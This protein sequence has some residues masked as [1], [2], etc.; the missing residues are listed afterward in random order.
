VIR[1]TFNPEMLVLARELRGLTQAELADISKTTQGYVSMLEHGQKEASGDILSRFSEVL[2]YPLSFFRQP[3]RYFGF[4]ITFVYHRKK[5]T[6]RVGDLRLLQAQVNLRRIHI[7]RMLRDV[8]VKTFANFTSFDIDDYNGDAEL[9]ANYVR[10][11]WKLPLG[12]IP[13]LVKT[14]E[15][16][17]GVVFKFSFGTTDVD[18]ISQWP[19]DGPP[20][21]FINADT[22]SDRI[23]YSL[24]HELGHVIMHKSATGEIETEADQFAAELLMPSRVILAQL[25]GMNIKLA[26][27]LKPYWR[28][29]MQSLIRRAR[30]LGKL[31]DTEYSRLFRQLSSHGMRKNE[32]MP[33]PGEEPSLVDQIILE[34]QRANHCTSAELAAILNLHEGEFLSIYA[35]TPSSGNGPRLVTR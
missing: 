15:A 26:A 5:S 31:C 10:A 13:N 29:S 19:D 12:P 18:A 7:A 27:R 28:V 30:N 2:D 21:F 20:M 3:E 17:G 16:A 4:G 35:P 1:A 25:D 9:I 24:A 22:P 11:N 32:P 6:A 34:F 23:R 33:I 14:I 8:P